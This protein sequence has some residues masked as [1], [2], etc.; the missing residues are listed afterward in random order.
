MACTRLTHTDF[1]SCSVTNLCL[2]VCDSMYCTTLG[3]PVLH[4]LL[5]FI[6]IH[7]YWV[8]DAIWTITGKKMKKA[9]PKCWELQFFFFFWWT[10]WGHE[11]RR[12]PLTLRDCSKHK[13]G[14]RV[15][16]VFAT[17]P[18]GQNIRILLLIKKNRHLKLMRFSDFCMGKC[19]SLGLVK[20][21]L[22]H[23]L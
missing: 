22:G 8:G 4:Y 20:S 10:F 21:L 18:D 7:V 11:P 13:R 15:F 9:Q 5:E 12:Q 17:K 19:R 6:E 23:V 3:F 14:A 1:C 16:R 2:T